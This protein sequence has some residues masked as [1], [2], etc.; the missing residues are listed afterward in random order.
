MR[1]KDIIQSDIKR[2]ML[3]GDKTKVA[4]LQLVKSAFLD[5]EVEHGRREEGLSDDDAIKVLVKEAKKRQES[6]DMFR[7]GGEASRAQAEEHERAIIEAYLPSS[8]SGEELSELVDA[9][10]S[11]LDAPTMRDMGRIISE[12]KKSAGPTAD[13]SV[14]A[15]KVKKALS[16]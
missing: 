2:A 13:G 3:A 16:E 6:A 15:A 11:K 10:I 14:I 8:L 12:V 7:R 5:F 4:V 9:E 1:I